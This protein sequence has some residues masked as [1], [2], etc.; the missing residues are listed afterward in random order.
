MDVLR[1][2]R[3]GLDLRR[4]GHRGRVRGGR[5]RHCFRG[6]GSRRGRGRYGHRGRR[7]RHGRRRRWGQRRCRG[8]GRRR[9]RRGRRRRHR[10]H[11]RSIRGSI[12]HSQ[13]AE[14]ES[15]RLHG[16]RRGRI[17]RRRR[18]RK[19]KRGWRRVRRH[20]ASVRR[21][22]FRGP[23]RRTAKLLHPI[24]HLLLDG[25]LVR[26]FTGL[27]LGSVLRHRGRRGLRRRRG[28]LGNRLRRGRRRHDVLAM[29]RNLH[30]GRHRRYRRRRRRRRH[31]HHRHHRHRLH[32]LRARRPHRHRRGLHARAARADRD[33]PEDVV[34]GL[35]QPAHDRIQL[36]SGMI[37]ERGDQDDACHVLRAPDTAPPATSGR[38]SARTNGGYSPAA[39]RRPALG[40]SLAAAGQEDRDPFEVGVHRCSAGPPRIRSRPAA[41]GP[42]SRRPRAASVRSGPSG[43]RSMSPARPRVR[44]R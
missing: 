26:A 44:A 10:C 40:A 4:D 37:A 39:Y 20:D 35:A 2:R 42:E 34:P 41:S 28:G 7:R 33:Q 16:K 43:S 1:A 15:G 23:G 17:G 18:R 36:E 24:L 14:T 5:H 38:P 9:R 13:I 30:V 21:R 19:R 22:C 25:S 11:V 32:R 3:N 31:R 6:I 8:R 12:G 27:L 29:L